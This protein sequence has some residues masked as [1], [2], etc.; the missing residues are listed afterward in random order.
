[1]KPLH[2]NT[3]SVYGFFLHIQFELLHWYEVCKFIFPI[4]SSCAALFVISLQWI[5][6]VNLITI[7]CAY[8]C[9][10]FSAAISCCTIYGSGYLVTICSCG[11]SYS[12]LFWKRM[13]CISFYTHISLCI[14]W[15]TYPSFWPIQIWHSSIGMLQ[16]SDGL[17]LQH[18]NFG[19]P[20][21]YG[22]CSFPD[23]ELL[24]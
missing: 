14:S 5:S 15:Y 1:L 13:L 16:R 23:L 10:L 3:I 12:S 11:A 17:H 19:N 6:L 2:L 9:Y 8:L 24:F 4:L 22:M 18:K 20:A 7:R 21:W